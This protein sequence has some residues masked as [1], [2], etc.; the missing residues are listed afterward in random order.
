MSKCRNLTVSQAHILRVIFANARPA[1]DSSLEV[2]FQ[3]C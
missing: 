1:L 3:W 2:R